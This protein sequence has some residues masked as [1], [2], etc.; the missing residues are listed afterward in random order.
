MKRIGAVISLIV[1]TVMLSG[2]SAFAETLELVSTTPKENSNTA[3]VNNM[4]IKL[5][6]SQNIAD[7]DAQKANAKAFVLK[8]PDGKVIGL[9]PYYNRERYPDEIWL[10]V[11][12][13]L[14][15][16][17]NYTLTVSQNLQ[18]STGDTLA[19]PIVFTFGTRDINKDAKIN[20]TMMFVMLGGM[21]VFS[22][23]DTRRRL[24][25]D[26]EKDTE[27]DKV[28]PYK[29]AKKTGKTVEEIVAKTEKE[30][31]KQRIKEEKKA[32]AEAKTIKTD[33]EPVRE[34]VKRVLRK[35]PIS[36]AGGKMPQ[37]MIEE[38]K[39]MKERKANAERQ[40]NK[41][42]VSSPNRKGSKQQQ[43]KRKN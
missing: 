13:N 6:F 37:N 29:E 38:R 23:W 7:E 28:N 36:A 24:R 12:E 10:S 43:R 9:T 32:I 19:E 31:E 17:T 34:G 8:G 1:L 5:K 27:D 18:S 39:A 25:K 2:I 22:L 20:T 11:K 15:S 41:K 26:Q 42:K 35:R 16:G 30:K 40:R 33:D 14:V 21:V 3:T 4:M